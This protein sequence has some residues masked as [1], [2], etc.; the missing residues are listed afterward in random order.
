[1]TARIWSLCDGQCQ[2]ILRGHKGIVPSVSVTSMAYQS[3]QSEQEDTDVI[4]CNLFAT[5][6]G[7]GHCRLWDVQNHGV[8][9]WQEMSG[10]SEGGAN[11]CMF[12]P[13]S[14]RRSNMLA[15]CHIDFARQEARVLMWDVQPGGKLWVDGKLTGPCRQLDNFRAKIEDLAFTQNDAGLLI[16]AC[17]SADG[18]IRVKQPNHTMPEIAAP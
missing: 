11:L 8:S 17:C 18:V 1:M 6:S 10:W 12:A 16:M 5:V 9:P 14:I 4:T 2:A 13:K 15:T 7:D 3:A